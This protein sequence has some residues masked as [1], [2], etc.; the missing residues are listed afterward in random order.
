MSTPIYPPDLSTSSN[1]ILDKLLP[2]STA[3]AGQQNPKSP[4]TAVINKTV[5]LEAKVVRRVAKYGFSRREQIKLKKSEPATVI[6]TTL[7]FLLLLQQCLHT[8]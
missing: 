4:T 1:L 7:L 8:P 3:S 6:I 5:I 2:V